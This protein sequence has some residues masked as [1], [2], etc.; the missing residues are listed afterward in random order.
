MRYFRSSHFCTCS[1]GSFGFMYYKNF[2]ITKSAIGVVELC[3]LK[4]KN[5]RLLACY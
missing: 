3:C 1:I 2:R 5:V 4:E